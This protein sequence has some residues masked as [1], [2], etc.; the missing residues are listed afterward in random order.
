LG[1]WFGHLDS[2]ILAYG[3]KIA[4][5]EREFGSFVPDFKKGEILNRAFGSNGPQ[6][7]KSGSS[8][9]E[10]LSIKDNG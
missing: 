5:M 1:H 2:S 6:K 8:S 9:R 4:S 10:K 7:N 3:F